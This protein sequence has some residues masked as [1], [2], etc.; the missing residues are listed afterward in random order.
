MILHKNSLDNIP[1]AYQPARSAP[2][3]NISTL[4]IIERQI[5]LMAVKAA[6]DHRLP[7]MGN[8][9]GSTKAALRCQSTNTDQKTVNNL[10]LSCQGGR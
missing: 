1:T 3:V 4:K 9:C 2:A 6:L 7:Q 5:V 10:A 8:R